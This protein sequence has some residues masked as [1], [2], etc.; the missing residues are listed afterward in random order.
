MNSTVLDRRMNGG[1][2][3]VPRPAAGENTYHR[4]LPGDA[5]LLTCE[6][7]DRE[8]SLKWSRQ[9]NVELPGNAKLTRNALE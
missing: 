8:A 6:S 9:N 5:V 2:A 3:P 4:V 7:S 1:E